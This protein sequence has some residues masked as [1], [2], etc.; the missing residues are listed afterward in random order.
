VKKGRVIVESQIA[1]QPDKGGV[2][3][4]HALCCS[5]SAGRPEW[6]VGIKS[7]GG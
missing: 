2:G 1:A 5:R 6:S 4:G 7:R 3:I